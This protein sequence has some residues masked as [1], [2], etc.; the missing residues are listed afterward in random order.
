MCGIFGA[1]K[2]GRGSLTLSTIANIAADQERRGPHAFGYAW[3]DADGRLHSYRQQGRI[4]KN[5][6]LLERMQGAKAIIGHTR[7]STH[8]DPGHL[9]N[10]HPHPSYGVWIVHNGVVSNH[11]TLNR[12]FDLLPSSDCDSETLGLL[13]EA[14]P[15]TLL[16]RVSETIDLVDNDAPLCIAG[17]W[18]AP[19]RV[20]MA[21]RGNP[22]HKSLG[23]TGNV[24]FGSIGIS[25]PGKAVEVQPD[26]ATV[27]DISKKT[28]T[29]MDLSPYLPGRT[30]A[31]SG[32]RM[33]T[34]A[35]VSP[36]QRYEVTPEEDADLR[37]K[38]DQILEDCGDF[39]DITDCCGG[40]IVPVEGD[41]FI[42]GDCCRSV[43]REGV[44]A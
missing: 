14:L 38:A 30:F 35:K 7:Y 32:T 12:D 42:C 41:H 11:E 5:L 24:Y 31:G 22:L 18:R 8:G 4:S 39:W 2:T 1:I 26:T 29:V 28:C 17:I 15:G 9:I 10:N 27:F 34:H 44:K 6:H 21:R 23:K 13:I 3:L 36:V 16:D 20:V 19:N 40:D 37:D 33:A 25:L 43:T